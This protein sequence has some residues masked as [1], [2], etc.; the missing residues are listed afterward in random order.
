[1]S[2]NKLIPQV[3]PRVSHPDISNMITNGLALINQ[4]QFDAAKSIFEKALMIEPNNYDAMQILGAVM[5][6]LGQFTKAVEL[7]TKAIRINANN[8]HTYS[9]LSNALKA[10]GYLDEA[11]QSS[12]KAIAINPKIAEAH[13]NKGAALEGLGRIDEALSSYDQALA[14]QPNYA[15]ALCNKGNILRK[16]NKLEEAIENYEKAIFIEPNQFK[17]YFNR[18]IAL[19]ERMLI[20]EALE[21]YE[22]SIALNPDSETYFSKSLLLL[23]TGHYKE[24]WDLYEWRWKTEEFNAST[25]YKNYPSWLGDRNQTVLVWSEQGIGDI[26]M[27]LS[28]IQEFKELCR[29][30]VVL[31]DG[32][33]LPLVNRLPHNKIIFLDASCPI[34]NIEF[35]AHIPIGSLGKFLRLSEGSFKNAPSRYLF[36][37]EQKTKDIR[38]QIYKISGSTKKI[39]G[40]SWRTTNIK[41]GGE[42]SIQL[43][44]L[45]DSFSPNEYQFVNLQYGDSKR[46]IEEAR[47]ATGH[48]V[49]Q[50]ESIDNFND[51]DGLASLI[52][53]CDSVISI[54]NSTAHLSGALGQDTRILLPF[55][56]NW[57]WLLDRMDCLWYPSAKLY[58]NNVSGDWQHALKMLRTDLDKTVH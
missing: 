44:K 27:F 39:Y 42:R 51:I 32:R 31:I 50:I 36:D 16:Q 55:R 45:I 56:P 25:L 20:K 4:H 22:K 54:D 40:I 21:S 29:K 48:H 5:I 26:I 52:K 30:T 28:L 1:M 11:L 19:E 8:A 43:A 24:G 37:E 3:T 33:L 38:D 53:A 47:I 2:R 23:L 34:E 14:I 18:G 9:N 46:E 35:D 41:K 49:I 7:L 13:M 6:Q 15:D 58:R 57:R 17:F 10:L 12:D